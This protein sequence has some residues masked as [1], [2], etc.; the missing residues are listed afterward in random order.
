MDLI[1]YYFAFCK[2]FENK[3]FPKMKFKDLDNNY[4]QLYQELYGVNEENINKATFLI[5]FITLIASIFFL[6]LLFPQFS[7]SIR[8]VTSFIISLFFAYNFNIF[9]YR[10]LKHD[11]RTL[12]GLR[13]LIELDFSLI[14]KSFPYNAEI[15]IKFIKLIINYNIP[16]SKSFKVIMT[17][18]HSGYNPET[19]LNNI[20]TASEDFNNFLDQLILNDFHLK[21]DMKESNASENSFKVYLK[22]VESRIS[23]IF[24]IGLFL[25]IGLCFLIL[26][27]TI[28]MIL[29]I[30]FVPFFLFILGYLFNYLLE[31]DY[32]LLGLLFNQ[33]SLERKR[34]DEFMIFLE[35][36][37][38]YLS[39]NLA[40]EQAF[41]KSY[42]KVKQR[43]PNLRTILRESIY[44]LLN[45]KFSF[46]AILNDLNLKLENYRYRII[47]KTLLRMLDE[48][49]IYTSEKIRSLLKLLYKH[50]SY[51]AELDIIIKSEKFK[52]FIFL[53]LLPL[54]IGG[55]S[56][57]FPYFLFINVMNYKVDE[58]SFTDFS[59]NLYVLLINPEIIFIFIILLSSNSIT[60][61]YFLKMI[62][63]NKKYMII[64]L[65][66]LIFFL[67]FFISL[68]SIINSF[69]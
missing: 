67:S 44:N 65:T 1:K 58:L 23:I 3:K 31:K 60:S 34:F 9:P 8:L 63:A 38:R 50:K 7:F 12:S 59:L 43:L 46:K 41:L 39:L 49:A 61:F 37:S 14:E 25:P 35:N 29:I 6:L 53:F 68:M 2:F 17:K 54:I 64:S 57:L 33:N 42:N 28:D 15:C 55:I 47:L 19:L 11:E 16:I 48:N 30:V 22:N 24:F 5:F 32:F 36:F 69:Q 20:K 13:Y 40:P 26:F 52:V 45:M 18:I 4:R 66:N 56:G 51:E 27:R 10:K 21:L 62:D